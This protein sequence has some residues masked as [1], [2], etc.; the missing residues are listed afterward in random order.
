MIL[1]CFYHALDW[2]GGSLLGL[3]MSKESTFIHSTRDSVN[4]ESN[5]SYI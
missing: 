1:L 3:S 5:Y 4:T 2:E